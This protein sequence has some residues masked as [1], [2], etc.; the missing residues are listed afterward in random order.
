METITNHLAEEKQVEFYFSHEFKN[1]GQWNLIAEV[2]YKGIKKTFKFH[3]T[4]SQFIDK[5]SHLRSDNATWDL[6]Q[7]TYKNKILNDTNIVDS[8]LYWISEIE[9]KITGTKRYPTNFI[10]Y[11]ETEQD[12][13]TIHIDT[14]GYID[15]DYHEL[16]EDMNEDYY[17]AEGLKHY[18]IRFAIQKLKDDGYIIT[19]ISEYNY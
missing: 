19:E 13:G 12:S 9:V 7:E 3:T 14:D 4:D 17:I 11:W 15:G 16:T 2:D 8:I 6:I 18:A 10:V 5:L 1:H